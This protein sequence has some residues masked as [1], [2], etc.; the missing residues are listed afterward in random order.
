MFGVVCRI[1]MYGSLA[2]STQNAITLELS[3]PAAAAPDG[4]LLCFTDPRV[5][6]ARANVSI[7]SV[8]EGGSIWQQTEAEQVPET[9]SDWRSASWFQSA[10]AAWGLQPVEVVG[11]AAGVLGTD[12]YY[13]RSFMSSKYDDLEADQDGVPIPPETFG[14]TSTAAATP[15][16]ASESSSAATGAS[17]TTG[18]CAL[19]TGAW[20]Q[21]QRY[22]IRLTVPNPDV[23]SA[24]VSPSVPAPVIWMAPLSYSKSSGSSRG[25]GS[26]SRGGGTGSGSAA[27]GDGGLTFAVRGSKQGATCAP[28]PALTA[29]VGAAL[30]DACGQAAALGV[31]VPDGGGVAACISALRTVAAG[32]TIIPVP[33][34]P[35]ALPPIRQLGLADALRNATCPLPGAARAPRLGGEC[36]MCGNGTAVGGRCVCYP[37]FEEQIAGSVA[38]GQ[39]LMMLAGSALSRAAAVTNAT[40]RAGIAQQLCQDYTAA[41][42]AMAEGRLADRVVGRLYL[43]A[44]LARA[45]LLVDRAAADAANATFWEEVDFDGRAPASP[46]RRHGVAPDCNRCR[47]GTFADIYTKQRVRLL[48]AGCVPCLLCCWLTK[49]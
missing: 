38:C 7:A 32:Q 25:S 46:S 8:L 28:R 33:P 20:K 45:G 43:G 37:G 47:G 10:T 17:R 11:T 31:T 18:S 15:P 44:F 9:A 48:A 12:G 29:A 19:I 13:S 35:L 41:K 42:T 26:S 5:S 30:F 4:V 3:T 39:P 27:V 49:S 16:P 2:L 23:P 34:S 36:I 24:S 1:L 21:Q 22:Q 6:F 14:G 40:N